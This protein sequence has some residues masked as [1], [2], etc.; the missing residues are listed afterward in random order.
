MVNAPLIRDAR[1]EDAADI[2]AIYAPYVTDTPI[3]FERERGGVE[4]RAETGPGSR[5]GEVGPELRVEACVR[6]VDG[7]G[8]ARGARHDGGLDVVSDDHVWSKVPCSPAELNNQSQVEGD[9]AEGRTGS[10]GA[11]G[12]PIRKAVVRPSARGFALAGGVGEKVRVVTGIGQGVEH[13][14]DQCLRSLRARKGEAR[15]VKR[16]HSVVELAGG[17]TDDADGQTPGE[18]ADDGTGELVRETGDQH[19]ALRE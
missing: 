8:N 16:S 19:R 13:D 4:Q 15:Q 11:N 3:S 10:K 6:N 7:G 18:P 5:F 17:A 2:A 12:R 1:A 9:L 14:A